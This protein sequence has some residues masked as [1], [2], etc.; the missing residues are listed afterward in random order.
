MSQA[1]C[2]L[3]SPYRAPQMEDHRAVCF[4][5]QMMLC[6]RHQIQTFFPLLHPQIHCH[7][8]IQG[9][10]WDHSH[11]PQTFTQFAVEIEHQLAEASDVY[12]KDGTPLSPSTRL[13]SGILDMLVKEVVKYKMYPESKDL[14]QVARALVAKH[15]CLG[16]QGTGY[17][18]WKISL[19][20][21]MNNYHQILKNAGY[22]ELSLN[23]M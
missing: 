19:G 2:L 18:G 14:E 22:P 21:K 6:P 9:H 11:G 12:R 17:G 3:M 4:K 13:R 10:P 1:L 8:P 23:S 5:D 7:P 20:T 15:P 16:K